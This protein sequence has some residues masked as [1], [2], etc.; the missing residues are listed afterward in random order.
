MR[1]AL[2]VIIT[3]AA[4]AAALPAMAQSYQVTFPILT[5]P[6]QPTSPDTDQSCVDMTTLDGATCTSPAK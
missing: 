1:R 6:D 2:L 5:Y 4:T 3:V